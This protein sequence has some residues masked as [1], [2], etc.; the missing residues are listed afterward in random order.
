MADDA[1]LVDVGYPADLAM[2]MLSSTEEDRTCYPCMCLNEHVLAALGVSGELPPVG[3]TMRLDCEVIVTS[4]SCDP[5][6]TKPHVTAHIRR[7]GA[8]EKPAEK[9]AD[10]WYGETEEPDGDE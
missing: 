8:H 6:G 1:H 4:A 3:A 10:R 7:M 9:R 5:D 2:S